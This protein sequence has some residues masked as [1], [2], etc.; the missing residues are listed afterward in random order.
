MK[1]K[2]S[3]LGKKPGYLLSQAMRAILPSNS[4]GF[5]I[6]GAQKC[7]TSSLHYYLNQHPDLVASR[8]KELHFFNREIY[9]DKDLRWYNSHF[10]H[11]YRKGKVFFESTPAYIYHPNTARHLYESYPE[12]CL[13][14]LLRDPVNRAYSAYNHYRDIFEKGLAN[15]SIWSKNRRQG[16]CLYERLYRNRTSFP[17]FRECINIELELLADNCEFEPSIL[18]RGLY[19]EQLKEYWRYF[20]KE[21]TLIIGF[22]DLIERTEQILTCVTDFVG[23]RDVGWSFLNRTPRNARF[24]PEPMHTEDNEF[25]EDFYLLPSRAL[26]EEI[27][28]VAW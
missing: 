2:L 15:R 28:P 20:S 6:I 24:Y 21:Q 8:P 22:K 1:R 12:I 18:R 10:K 4:P 7:G 26:F 9:F 19:L 16:N 25:L 13:L 3:L 5:I 27:G 14:V 11:M 17:T 23:A